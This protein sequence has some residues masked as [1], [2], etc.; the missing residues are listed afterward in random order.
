MSKSTGGG[1]GGQPG[2]SFFFFSGTF[3]G[4]ASTIIDGAFL[5]CAARFGGAVLKGGNTGGSVFG[6]GI[7]PGIANMLGGPCGISVLADA[8]TICGRGISST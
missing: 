1:P 6:N 7:L 5:W 3:S 8:V 2:G 4:I